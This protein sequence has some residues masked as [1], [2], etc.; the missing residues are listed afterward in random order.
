M[1]RCQETDQGVGDTVVQGA[2]RARQCD[3][4]FDDLGV[5]RHLRSILVSAV[6]GFWL[7]R[8]ARC[9]VNVIGMV[10]SQNRTRPAAGA[11]GAPGLPPPADR[12]TF[13]AELDALRVRA[14]RSPCLRRSR[15]RPAAGRPDDIGA[16][17]DDPE[18]QYNQN[19]KE[20][21]ND[22][23]QNRNA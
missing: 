20:G 1:A 12:A 9:V 4:Q 5:T 22:R 3:S 21:D 23:T 17:N 11:T 15:P 16:G 14:A 10:R 2:A 6:G 18:E 19:R 8:P 13:Q 7:S